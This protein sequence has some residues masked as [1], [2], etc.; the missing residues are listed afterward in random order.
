[1]N[2]TATFAF[3]I[4]DR[5]FGTMTAFVHGPEADN[6]RF[7][8]ALPAQLLK[9]IAPALQP[10]IDPGVTKTADTGKPQTGL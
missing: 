4:G 1:V 5:F 2:R 10:L 8:S 3:Y 7:T 6:Y 9:S